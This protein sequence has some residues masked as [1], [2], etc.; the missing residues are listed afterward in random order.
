MTEFD[1]RESHPN[2]SAEG[3]GER[4]QKV[5]ARAGVAS[6]RA[7]ELLI[8]AGRVDVNGE[9]VTTLGTRIDPE[10]A[11]VRVDG[12]R[13]PTSTQKTYVLFNKPRGMVT[14]M[15]D[16]QSR[17]CV[18]DVVA[19]RSDRLF[20][21]G[22]L[23]TDTD[24]VLLLT[25]DGELANQL[26]HPS[27][28]VSKTYVAQVRAPVARDV[29]RRLREGIELDDGPVQAESFRVIQQNIGKALVEVVVHEGR[30]HVVRRMLEAVGNP[31]ETLTRTQ[32]GP[33]RLGDLRT[34][35]MRPLD[36]REVGALLDAAPSEDG[37][38]PP[39]ARRSARPGRSTPPGKGIRAPRIDPSAGP[40]RTPG[41]APSRTPGRAPD[42]AP[43][44][45]SSRAPGRD[46]T[47]SSG[48]GASPDRAP[49][50]RD[51]APSGRDRAPS[52]RDQTPARPQ[53]R[54]AA[55]SRAAPSRAAPS[56]AAPSRAAP[57][58]SSSG[59]ST[60]G[61]STTDRAPTGRDRAPTVRDR[62]PMG[63]DRAPTG[64]N[65]TGRNATGRSGSGR[66]D[67]SSRGTTSRGNPARGNTDRGSASDRRGQD[68][69]PR[70][71]SR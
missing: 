1:D 34:G 33:L 11:V 30:K 25:N 62:A 13:V 28:G 32:F 40:S 45:A 14:T 57:S 61:R 43:S 24:G 7:S 20:H 3:E 46:R 38:A 53:D 5:L 23:D 52:G 8:S 37:A 41:R 68:R 18:G 21:V 2:E 64:R 9:V 27:F 66:G 60:T 70:G 59:R 55:P 50:G 12:E 49:L 31:V 4:L 35:R 48:R 22:R 65:A 16:P 42:R 6:R 44:R 54:R 36:S 29:G 58:R 56:R 15:S 10:T 67:A 26:S 51:R 19:G 69:R 47:Q 71:G 17:P 63:R 39:A